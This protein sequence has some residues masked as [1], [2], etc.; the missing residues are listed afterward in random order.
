MDTNQVSITDYNDTDYEQGFWSQRTY[1]DLLEKDHLASLLPLN[2]HQVIDVGGGFGRLSTVYVPRTSGQ[3]VLFDYS[4]KLLASARNKHNYPQ[5]KMVQGSFYNLP[6]SSGKF[7]VALSVRVIH[8]VEDVPLYLSEI[9]RVLKKDG[10]FILEF[11]NKRNLLEILR[12]VFR[13]SRTN[14]FERNPQNRSDKGLTINFHPSYIRDQVHL[15]GFEIVEQRASSLL[16]LPI[17]KKLIGQ[18]RLFHLEKTLP[19]FLKRHSLS[20]SIF[21]KLRKR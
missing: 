14:P 5:L 17:L 15:A 11:A 21:L 10:L 8:H 18:A 9:S 16:R 6:F 12:W 13:K 4:E 20:P 19:L 3:A 7:D 1:E 2:I